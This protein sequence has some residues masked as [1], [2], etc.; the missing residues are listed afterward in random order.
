MRTQ[1]EIR[2]QF[3]KEHEGLAGITKKKITDYSG[4]GKMYNTDTR[5]AFINYVDM[6]NCNGI[7]SQEL[8]Q[9]ITL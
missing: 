2:R 9:K 8:A 5:T 4:E 1:R 3:W 6:L 7:I